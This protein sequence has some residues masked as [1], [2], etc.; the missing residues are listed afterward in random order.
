M[1]GLYHK[2]NKPVRL[3][4]M[5]IMGTLQ[6]SSQNLNVIKLFPLF[7][8]PSNSPGLSTV[9]TN[10]GDGPSLPPMKCSFPSAVLEQAGKERCPAQGC[11]SDEGLDGDD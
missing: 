10:P 3:V 9:I 1:G 2:D 11:A 8:S 5:E 6:L 4:V 7:P